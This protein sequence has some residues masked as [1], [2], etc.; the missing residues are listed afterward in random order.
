MRLLPGEQ[1]E[2][3]KLLD[4]YDLSD[5]YILVKRRGWIHIEIYGNMFA[6]HRK[7]SA[8]LIQG[9]FE[10]QFH[11]FVRINTQAKSVNGFSEVLKEFAIWLNE[12][13]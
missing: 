8:Q 9:K 3:L 6:F 4:Q 10:D 5:Q 1:A 2:I 13:D 7:K 11:Y 12:L